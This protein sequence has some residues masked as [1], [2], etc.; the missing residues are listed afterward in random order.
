MQKIVR[1]CNSIQHPKQEQESCNKISKTQDK[2]TK[3]IGSFQIEA[4]IIL[5]PSSFFL[6]FFPH[7]NP[8][9]MHVLIIFL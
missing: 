7:N 9:K 6:S 8:P 5:N 2:Q 4:Q 3:I 1:K